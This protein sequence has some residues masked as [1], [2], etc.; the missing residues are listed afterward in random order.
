MVIPVAYFK[1]FLVPW[2]LTHKLLYPSHL[3]SVKVA[4]FQ[5]MQIAIG[6]LWRSEAS[7]IDPHKFSEV[8]QFAFGV[9]NGSSTG[10][11]RQPTA[12]SLMRSSGYSYNVSLG[13]ADETEI[14]GIPEFAGT[15]EQFD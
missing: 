8:A 13:F 5:A 3:Q 11:E 14:K 6:N 7:K 15:Q 2:V 1:D 12:A 4:D 9:R 10:T